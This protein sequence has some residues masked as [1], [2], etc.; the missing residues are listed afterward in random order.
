MKSLLIWKASTYE[1]YKFRGLDK[2]ATLTEK[3]SKNKKNLVYLNTT[4]Y[5]F[6]VLAR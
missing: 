4:Y 3:L 1:W 6:V 5:G 2:N